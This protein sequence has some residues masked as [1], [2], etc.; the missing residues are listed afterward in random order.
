MRRRFDPGWN[1][2]SGS[3]FSL[4]IYVRYFSVQDERKWTITQNQEIQ[5]LPRNLPDL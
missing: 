2:G 3:N 4:E 1:P 5:S